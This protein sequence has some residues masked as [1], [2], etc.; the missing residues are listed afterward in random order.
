MVEVLTRGPEFG[1]KVYI[2]FCA[3]CG[4]KIQWKEAEAAVVEEVN[5]GT[6]SVVHCPVCGERVS[7]GINHYVGRHCGH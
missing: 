5:V 3:K 4:S 2:A 7:C 6:F 1:E